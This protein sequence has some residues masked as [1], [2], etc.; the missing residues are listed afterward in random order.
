MNWKDEYSLGIEEIDD[1]HKLLLLGFSAVE[2]TIKQDKGWS[3]IHFSIVELKAL[4]RMHFSFEEALMRLFGFSEI[5]EHS[6]E[7]EHFFVKLEEIENHSLRNSLGAEILK[8]LHEWLTKHIRGVDKDY[9]LHILSGASVVRSS[10]PHLTQSL[11]A[12]CH[13]M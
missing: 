5:K 1:Q 10:T 9:A 12:Q 8:F 13:P 2:D 7:H 11:A 4:A 6:S 3:D